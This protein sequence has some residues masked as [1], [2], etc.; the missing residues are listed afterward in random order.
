MITYLNYFLRTNNENK[1][2][3]RYLNQFYVNSSLPFQE[4]CADE[5]GLHLRVCLRFGVAE[6]VLQSAVYLV[7]MGPNLSEVAFKSLFLNKFH[8][9]YSNLSLI[10]YGPL[11]NREIVEK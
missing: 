10:P 8:E 5:A 6:S 2:V 4:T 9:K 1:N 3:L 7:T 11:E